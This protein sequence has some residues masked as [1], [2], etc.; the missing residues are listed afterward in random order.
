[1][2]APD[3]LRVSFVLPASRERLY[4]AFLD[5]K[6]HAA[7]T[8]Y[9]VTGSAKVGGKFTAGDGTITGKYL[10]LHPHEK[11]VQAW[12]TTDFP[13]DAPDSRL[14]ITFAPA[15]GGTRVTLD[16]TELPPGQG[17]RIERGWRRFYVT[18]M[19]E[20]FRADEAPTS[21]APA[22]KSEKTKAA[23]KSRRPRS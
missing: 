16:H 7:F 10:E 13:E 11:I 23:A 17:E 5:A 4:E 1:M 3:S 14:E 21:S 6:E 20:Y 15:S 19:R 18:P 9:A 12:R 22:R 8:G 2:P